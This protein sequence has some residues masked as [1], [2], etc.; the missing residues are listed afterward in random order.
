MTCDAFRG[1]ASG[2]IAHPISRGHVG[3]PRA[4]RANLI[5]D[6][7]AMPAVSAPKP[8]RLAKTEISCR[9][10]RARPLE[11]VRTVASAI[12][13][14]NFE[15]AARKPVLRKTRFPKRRPRRAGRISSA[16][17]LFP[18]PCRCRHTI[19]NPGVPR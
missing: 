13:A 16:G 1:G 6:F 12:A 5:R 7:A 9:R 19:L 18:K 10:F 3:I 14:P 11:P 17:D 4:E 8:A 15:V 2:S